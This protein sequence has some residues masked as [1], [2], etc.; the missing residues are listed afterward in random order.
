MWRNPPW[1]VGSLDL[2]GALDRGPDTALIRWRQVWVAQTGEQGKTESGIRSAEEKGWRKDNEPWWFGLMVRAL[3][4]RPKGLRFDSQ[5]GARTSVVSSLALVGVHVGGDQSMSLSH[6]VDVFLSPPFFLSSTLSIK[7][8]EKYI[9]VRKEGRKGWERE[10]EKEGGRMRATKEEIMV[11]WNPSKWTLCI[12]K[13][14]WQGWWQGTW[15]CL[16]NSLCAPMINQPVF[17]LRDTQ[18]LGHSN[19]FWF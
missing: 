8:W 9:Q 11:S 19:Q 16:L 18:V 2:E 6:H 15:Q 12:W 14:A 5:S 1:W 17:F 10:G 7:Q 3:V 13:V 4:C